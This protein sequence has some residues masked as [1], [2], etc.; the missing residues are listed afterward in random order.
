M[1]E[2][3]DLRGTIQLVVSTDGEN[4]FASFVYTDPET[5]SSNISDP[6]MAVIGFDGGDASGADF[7]AFLL[8]SNRNLQRMHTFRI[9]GMKIVG[10]V[11]PNIRLDH[12]HLCGFWTIMCGQCL[13]QGIKLG[14][15]ATFFAFYNYNTF[16]AF[17]C[18]FTG[19]KNYSL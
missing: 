10:W 1:T 5:V 12:S 13:S 14:P 17:S 15:T 19:L 6:Q 7:G 9:D 2:P 8:R 3:G 18:M 4:S 11:C 16:R